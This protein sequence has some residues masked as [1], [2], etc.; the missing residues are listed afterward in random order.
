MSAGY[1]LPSQFSAG[2]TASPYPG[3][4]AATVNDWKVY[5]P[6]QAWQRMEPRWRLIEA[7]HG[8]TLGIRAGATKWLPQEPREDDVSYQRRLNGSVCPPYLVRLEAML[9]VADHSASLIITGNGDV[10]EPEHGIVAI[11]SGGAYAQSAA[12]ALQFYFYV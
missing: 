1:L 2:T 3:T 8:G 6:C 9:A 12:K 11:G 10:L 4:T 7:L 5:Q